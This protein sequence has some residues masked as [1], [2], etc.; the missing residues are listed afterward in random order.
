[1][2][3]LIHFLIR[4]HLFILFLILQLVSFMFIINA[5]DF[6]R[7]AYFNSTSQIA[8]GALEKYHEIESFVNL[9]ETNISL[10]RENASLKSSRASSYFPLF[11]VNDSIVDTLYKQQ[12]VFVEAQIVNS[13]FTYQ[14]NF[15]TINKGSR[16]GV[17]KGM[18][19]INTNG[20]LGIIKDVSSNYSIAIPIINVKQKTTGRIAGTAYFGSISWNGKDYK[21]VQLSSIQKQAKFETGDTVV[22]DIR[23]KSYPSGIP[24]GIIESA[25]VDPRNQLFTLELSLLP[26]FANVDHVYLIKDLLKEELTQLENS[27]EHGN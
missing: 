20:A 12:Y 26:D 25:M 24:I 17:E 11:N 14:N 19:V 18:G 9:K 16:H 10:A 8:G 13:S 23:S 22:T 27:I 3:R 6:H 21:R 4:N 1:M 2:Q 15:L 5:Q 7:A